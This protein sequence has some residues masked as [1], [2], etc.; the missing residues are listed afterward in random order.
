[1]ALLKLSSKCKGQGC[2][3]G[4]GPAELEQRR[5]GWGSVPG[6]VQ[7][8]LRVPPHIAEELG[9]A[10]VGGLWTA[11]HVKKKVWQGLVRNVGAFPCTGWAAGQGRG[12]GGDF[13]ISF[14][15]E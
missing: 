1:M 3:E 14:C 2:K 6:D 12:W 13:I 7:R 10:L 11:P 5:G 4:P 15:M 9:E 8:E